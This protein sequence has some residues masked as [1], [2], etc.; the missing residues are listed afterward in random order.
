MPH[1]GR[2]VGGVCSCFMARGCE[3]RGPSLIGLQKD[4]GTFSLHV[5]D[6]LQNSWFVRFKNMKNEP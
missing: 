4:V 5:S 1:G 2:G 3:V 6:L